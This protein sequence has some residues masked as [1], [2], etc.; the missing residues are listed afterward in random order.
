MFSANRTIHIFLKRSK[1]F[2]LFLFLATHAY[3]VL[4]SNILPDT[5]P[6]LSRSDRDAEFE[7]N[8]ENWK[9]FLTKNIRGEVPEK[10]NAPNGRY[11]VAVTFIVNTDGTVGD[12]GIVADP[13]YGAAEELV[14]VIKLSSGNWKP[15]VKNGKEIKAFKVQPMTFEVNGKRTVSNFKL[16][17]VIRNYG[18]E[19]FD[20]MLRPISW[21]P[22][23]TKSQYIIIPASIAHSGAASMLITSKPDAS[24][25]RGVGL[26]NTILTKNLLENKKKISI[27]AFIKTENLADGTASIWVQLNGKGLII[28]DKNSDEESAK[29]SSDWTKYTIE[30]SLTN[31]VQSV[32][33]GCKMNGTGKAWFDD[34]E[35]LIDDVVL[36]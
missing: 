15:A 35:V 36:K 21:S 13:G 9:S 25:D 28:A 33:F 3:N 30:L 4:G 29:G 20:V 7:K 24:T 5:I 22:Q 26:Y 1:I 32:A 6:V 23:N 27:S 19:D 12:I 10:N 14:R 16:P 8:G 31:E 17:A 18:F 11:E 34:F 2:L